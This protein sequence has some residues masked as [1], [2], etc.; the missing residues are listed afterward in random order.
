MAIVPP[1]NVQLLEE[2]SVDVV[3]SS[4]THWRHGTYESVIFHRPSDA[5]YWCAHYCL[6]TDGETN[7]LRDG[8][9]HIT[10]V[11]PVEVM[12]T[13]YIPFKEDAIR[14][15][16]GRPSSPSRERVEVLEE[17]LRRLAIA[18]VPSGGSCN[19]CKAEW[20][21]LDMNNKPIDGKEWHKLDC[22]LFKAPSDG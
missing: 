16:A 6:S 19:L 15:V 10:R 4:C 13:Q 9:A 14:V 11:M 12:S 3:H 21:T 17:A 22:L 8:G 20:D 18:R 2:E 1:T 7:E 5:T